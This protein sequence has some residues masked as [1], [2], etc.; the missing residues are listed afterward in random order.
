MSSA[1]KR[2]AKNTLMLYFRQFF[3]MGL[4]FYTVRE[5]LNVLG[6]EDYGIYNVVAGTVMLLSFLTNTMSSATQRFFSFELG[7]NDQEMLKC[8]F[9]TNLVIYCGIV[10]IAVFLFETA[11]LWFVHTKMRIPPEKIEEARL[12][13]QFAVAGFL[14]SLVSSPYIAIIIAH[15]EMNFY[16]YIS[17]LDAILKLGAVIIIPFL[18]FAKLPLYGALLCIEA[19]VIASVYCLFCSFK[20]KEC[21]FS[22]LRFKRAM[23]KEIMNFTGWTL[24]GCAST[25]IRC[26]AVTILVNQYFNPAIVAA[27]AIALNASG[28]LNSF[29]SNFNTGLYPPIIKAWSENNREEMFHLV[30]WGSKVAFFLTWIFSLPCFLEM[31]FILQLWL[32]K[33][34]SHAVLFT[35]LI[36]I[37]SIIM[38]VSL[39]VTTAARAPGKM[40]SYELPLGII[41]VLIFPVSLLVLW[42][43]GEAYTTLVVAILANIVMFFIRLY[44]VRNLTGLPLKPFAIQVM[45]PICLT[46]VAAFLLSYSVQIFLPDFSL[47]PLVVMFF[48]CIISIVSIGV[49]GIKASERNTIITILKNKFGWFT[50]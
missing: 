34:P 33:V 31:D 10:L 44:I 6:V 39:P 19:F 35:R 46:S 12:L 43:G 5:V 32:K 45:K 17:M 11:G 16:A 47:K 37:E 25:I 2:I 26:Q 7:R 48:S 50:L 20:Y 21:S 42:L 24:F 38:S 15:E 8:V 29:A 28:A 41:Q 13:Y 27:R 49:L 36:L 22:G 18:P 40:S 23:L 9:G 4:S 30:F 3:C 14:A 1:T